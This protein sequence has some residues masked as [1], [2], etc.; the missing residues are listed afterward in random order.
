MRPMFQVKPATRK[1]VRTLQDTHSQHTSVQFNLFTSAERTPR[2]WLKS[3]EL[4]C[5]LCAL[6]KNL[7]SGLHMSHPLL[8]SHLPRTTSTSSSSFNLPSTTTQE[9]AAQSGQHDHLQ[10]HPV[11]PSTSPCSPSRQAAPSRHSGEKTCRVAETR[12]RRLQQVMSPKSLRLSRGSKIILEIHINYM[13]HRKSLE[14]KFTELRSPKK[15]RN[16]EKL[17]RTA[18]RIQ[19]Y[20]R[21]PTSNRRCISKIPWKALQI[22]ISKMESYKSC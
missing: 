3:H 15:R 14:N 6:E 2:A 17:G 16:L 12:A 18:Y 21:R 20:Q 11:H 13:M 4:Q 10:E 19:K 8:L 1:L 7:S 9:H 22:L 5:H